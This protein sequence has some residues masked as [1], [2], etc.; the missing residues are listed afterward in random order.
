MWVNELSVSVFEETV[1]F[2]Y[3]GATF[4]AAKNLW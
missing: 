3:Y 1:R 4:V 2:R